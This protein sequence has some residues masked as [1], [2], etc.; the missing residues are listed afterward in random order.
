MCRFMVEGF[1]CELQLGS[2]SCWNQAKGKSIRNK[3]GNRIE[4]VN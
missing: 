4:T 1:V 2:R 3:K